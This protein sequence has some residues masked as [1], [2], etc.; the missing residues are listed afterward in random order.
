VTDQNA[1]SLPN[2]HGWTVMQTDTGELLLLPIWLHRDADGEATVFIAHPGGVM[3]DGSIDP[4]IGDLRHSARCILAACQSVG[5]QRIYGQ[6]AVRRLLEQVR[7]EGD[8]TTLEDLIERG[9][10]PDKGFEEF[11]TQVRAEG[12]EQVSQLFADIRDQLQKMAE[13]DD[14]AAGSSDDQK[15]PQS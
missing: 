6:D 11:Q 10:Q 4:N 7:P 5:D 1:A 3:V 14:P 13:K 8:T 9:R 15:G 12:Y 2:P